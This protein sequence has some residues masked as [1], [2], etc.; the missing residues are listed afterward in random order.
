MILVL[1]FGPLAPFSDFGLVFRSPV[2]TNFGGH[3]SALVL[4]FGP[5]S[6]GRFTRSRWR[7]W[8]T[9]SQWQLEPQ[10]SGFQDH[11][12]PYITILEGP[13]SGLAQQRLGSP[14]RHK[15]G[16]QYG[17]GGRVERVGQ[18]LGMGIRSPAGRKYTG[19]GSGLSQ[20][21]GPVFPLSLFT[22]AEFRKFTN[23]PKAL[24]R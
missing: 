17:L 19:N 10:G 20:V 15:H 7:L 9:R 18:Q 12:K 4:L 5:L 22:E 6:A 11:F 21:V 1:F 3:F 23:T 8:F 2:R 16:R 14:A 24:T 13:V